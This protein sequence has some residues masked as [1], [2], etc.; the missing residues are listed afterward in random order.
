MSDQNQPVRRY[1]YQLTRADWAAFVKEVA[2]TPD[3]LSYVL[4]ASLFLCGMLWAILRDLDFTALGRLL[5]IG[6]AAALGFLLAK[7]CR[8]A[9]DWLKIRRK[10]LPT[11]PLIVEEFADHLAVIEGETRT[12][13]PWDKFAR[14]HLGKEHVFLATSP[15]DCVILPLRAFRDREDM[16][17]F[18]QLAEAR[19]E[20]PRQ[21]AVDDDEVTYVPPTEPL[22]ISFTSKAQDTV[23]TSKITRVEHMGLPKAALFTTILGGII[24]GGLS[25]FW[26]HDG[27]WDLKLWAAT[28]WPGAILLTW[29]GALRINSQWNNVWRPQDHVATSRDFTI[30]AEGLHIHSDTFDTHLKWDGIV[31]V[32]D[33]ETHVLFT[34]LWR[35]VFAVPKT[36]FTVNPTSFAFYLAASAWKIDAMAAQREAEHVQNPE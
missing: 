25:S 17:Q 6:T 31:D 20:D 22:T 33:G 7:L 36:A 24:T 4:V 18:S 27:E 30:S 11:Q 16:A 35:E 8:L 19:G 34:T 2:P 21:N 1:S 15:R 12:A 32:I 29:I 9:L 3:R 5:V 13:Y 26:A 28:A 14:I 23:D 10:I